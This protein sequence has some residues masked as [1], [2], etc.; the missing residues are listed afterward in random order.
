MEE[1]NTKIKKYQKDNLNDTLKRDYISSL[2]DEKFSSLVKKLRLKD[3]VGMKYTSKLEHT[4]ENLKNCEKCKSLNAC[5]NEVLG[6][7]Y[8]PT[9]TDE[10]LEFNYVQCKYKNKNDL[11]NKN[12]SICY[13]LSNDLK[14]ASMSDIDINDKKRVDLIKWLKKFYDE[15]PESKKGLYLHGSFGSGKTYLVA[16]LLNELAKKDYKVIMMYYPEMLSILKSSF[17]NN[18]EDG[19]DSYSK[20]LDNIK[21]CDLL[22]IDDIGAETVTNW[23]RDEVLGTILQYRM[24]HNLVT[25]LTSNLNIEELETH[26]SLVKNNMDKV[27][28]RRIIE[29]IK[30]LTEDIELVSVNRRN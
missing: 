30:Q 22:L 18:N 4:I 16:A 1:L 27:K 2:K 15:Y 7:V 8:Y 6:C 25:F 10:K 19:I 3:E 13:G 5:K 11:E 28:A 21:S 23:S 17:D 14:N 20:N 29:R 26:L 12:K 24:E 9:K